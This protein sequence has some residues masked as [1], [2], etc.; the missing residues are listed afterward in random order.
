MFIQYTSLIIP[1]KDRPKKLKNLIESM[2]NLIFEINE[3][4]IVDSSNKEN[5][6]FNKNFFSKFKNAKLI[7]SIPS[8]SKQRNLGIENCNKENKFLMFCD[9]DI[10][11]E[12]NSINIMS[13]F[14]RSNE[15]YMGYGFNLI[16]KN[17]N[18]FFERLKKHKFLEKNGFYN[19]QPGVICENGWHTKNSN[20]VENLETSWLSTQACIYRSTVFNDSKFDTSLGNYSYLEDLFFSFNVSKKGKLFICSQAKYN[21][22]NSI[23]RTSFTFG[24]QETINRHKFVKMNNFNIKKFY[25]SILI[26]TLFSLLNVLIGKINFFPKFVGNFFGIFLCILK[27]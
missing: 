5:I 9:D 25:L 23:N 15:N 17:E 19:S 22:G 27:K 10:V 18:S 7:E 14:M 2:E 13:D 21:H 20:L 3:I 16:E 6:E 4:I 12:K 26:K 1:T 11:F 8:T 24:L